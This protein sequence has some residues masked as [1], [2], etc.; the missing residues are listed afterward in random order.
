MNP[1]WGLD[2][3]DALLPRPWSRTVRLTHHECDNTVC[4][5]V[6]FT[7]GTGFP[8]L[9]SPREPHRRRRHDWIEA[10]VRRGPLHVLRPDDALG[11]CARSPRPD[12]T[13]GSAC[14]RSLV[15]DAAGHRRPLRAAGRRAE[16]QCFLPESQRAPS[17][18]STR[19]GRGYHALHVCPATATSTCSSGATPAGTSSRLILEELEPMRL[20]RRLR[21]LRGRLLRSS[22]AS[23][24]TCPINSERLAGAD[25]GVLGRLPTARDG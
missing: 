14:P 4:R 18:S 23:P 9:W 25:G 12:R 7:Y 10:R 19:H 6:S 1:R 8:C 21:R 15:A 16:N 2:A 20:P 3:A 11:A 17:R 22:T 24:T 13:T 5:M